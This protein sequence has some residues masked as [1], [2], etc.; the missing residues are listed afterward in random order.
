MLYAAFYSRLTRNQMLRRS[1][2]THPHGAR[3]GLP[4]RS[5]IGITR[6]GPG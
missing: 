2:R 5:V 1:A 6:C 4:E 3:Q